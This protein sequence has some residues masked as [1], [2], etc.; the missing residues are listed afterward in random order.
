MLFI[1]SLEP[2]SDLRQTWPVCC[3]GLKKVQCPMCFLS[4]NRRWHLKSLST[5][6]SRITAMFS[7]VWQP[8]SSVVAVQHGKN[9]CYHPDFK[10]Q[11]S[12]MSLWAVQKLQTGSVKAVRALFDILNLPLICFCLFL[13]S[14]FQFIMTTLKLCKPAPGQQLQI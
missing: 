12:P 1:L 13:W 11:V 5:V 2:S 8:P 6:V 9:H 14:V 7:V 10:Y 3:W 4:D